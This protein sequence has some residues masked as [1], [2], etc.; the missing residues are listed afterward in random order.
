MIIRIVMKIFQ[1][2]GQSL[3]CPGGYRAYMGHKRHSLNGYSLIIILFLTLA[4][5]SCKPARINQVHIELEKLPDGMYEGHAKHVNEARVL[6]S[7]QNNQISHLEILSLDATSFGRKAKDSIPARI[8]AHQSPYVDAVS[9]ATE[10]SHVIINAT[11]DA[12][13]KAQSKADSLNA[14]PRDRGKTPPKE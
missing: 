5:G 4:L 1:G 12:L 14:S 6:L 9:G 3:L 7:I 10:A 8:L 2:I 13:I 11:L